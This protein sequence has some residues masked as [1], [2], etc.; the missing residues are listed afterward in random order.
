[1]KKLIKSGFLSYT[2][3]YPHYPLTKK[4]KQ[5]NPVVTERNMRFVNC[6]GNKE[7]VRILK[8]GQNRF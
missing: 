8:N 5:D 2:R 7:N 1:M 4:R 3:G 6:A